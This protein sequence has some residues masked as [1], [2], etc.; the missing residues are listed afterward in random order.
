VEQWRFN[1]QLLLTISI[2]CFG[3]A[4][5]LFQIDS[6]GNKNHI[7]SNVIVDISSSQNGFFFCAWLF[8]IFSS[9]LINGLLCT[10]AKIILRAGNMDGHVLD[11]FMGIADCVAS[12][13]LRLIWRVRAQTLAI[14]AFFVGCLAG[15]AVFQ[16]AFGAAA[17][18]FACLALSPLWILGSALLLWRRRTLTPKSPETHDIGADYN[19][20]FFNF[21]ASDVEIS[22][23]VAV[24]SPEISGGD[25]VAMVQTAAAA[26]VVE[27]GGSNALL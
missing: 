9:A 23:N 1:H 17:L 26:A 8:N 6:G 20:E 14:A 4:H 11:A 18:C 25:A 15:S 16:S 2:T 24:S 27:Q 13:S 3:L 19:D 12:R 10:G 21:Q 7:L 22:D 5:A